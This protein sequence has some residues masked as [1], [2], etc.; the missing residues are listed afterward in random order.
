M[1]ETVEIFGEYNKFLD[2]PFYTGISCVM[3]MQSF[4]LRL[5]APTST[6]TQIEVA[7]KFSGDNGIILQ[8]TTTN[9]L[10]SN[11]SRLTGF[12]VSWISQFKEEDERYLYPL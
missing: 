2:P 4:S 5:S 8:L 6:S 10:E 1:R 11:S 7:I 12:D 3:E 9:M